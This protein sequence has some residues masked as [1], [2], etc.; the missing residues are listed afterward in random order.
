MN[1]NNY[2][3]YLISINLTN[4]CNL[5]CPHCYL[6]AENRNFDSS[7]ALFLKDLK[8]VFEN[9]AEMAPGTII[10]L[11]GGE[12]L[13]HPDLENIIACGKKL[14]L[15]MVMGTN[16]VL[17][18]KELLVRLKKAGL[19]GVSIS[20]DSVS[21]E[22][23]DSFRG[24]VGSFVKSCDAFRI[25][26]DLS[27][28][29]Q[30]NFTVSHNNLN[31]IETLPSLAKELGASM[32]NYFFLVCVGRGESKL[33]I[34]P[35]QYEDALTLIA[36]MQQK[37]KGLMIQARCAPHYK[38]ILYNE[39]KNSAFTR[40]SGYDGGGCL[41]ATHYCRISY[42]GEVTPCPY[43]ELSAGN[44]KDKSFHE[45]WKSSILFKNLR[46][47]EQLQGKCSVCEYKLLCGGC[48]ARS[49]AQLG[50]LLDE[51]PNCV[52]IP[53]GGDL[54]EPASFEKNNKVEWTDEAKLRLKRI[55][56]F[57]RIMVKKKLEE[58]AKREGGVV[59]PELMQRHKEERE[60]Q[61]GIKFN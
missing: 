33:D 29:S 12:P 37:E 14:G 6:D 38:R 2:L 3:P 19:E 47:P 22:S 55:P 16:G 26:R 50:N 43:M 25:C 24:Q 31:E 32:V 40:A 61:L 10:I 5:D 59:T 8:P 1:S 57:V 60:N 20:L 35:Q 4:A 56:L 52:Y 13:L 41:A 17:F 23:H 51:D 7:N 9:V 30:V 36:R 11:T 34:T 45:I 44:I 28:H 53:E 54:V 18:T 27:L 42:N 58:R 39:D 21:P 15:R 49:L 48:R 46:D